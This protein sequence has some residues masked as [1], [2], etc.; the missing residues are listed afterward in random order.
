MKR[1]MQE[2]CENPHCVFALAA[3]IP[4]TC[5]LS[6]KG[7]V[8]VSCAGCKERNVRNAA[9]AL[10]VPGAR[11]RERGRENTE[12]M[13]MTKFVIGD[14][15]GNFK[16]LKEVLTLSGLDYDKDKLII[17]GDVCDGHNQTKECVDE[18]LKIK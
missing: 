14:I 6:A 13:Q 9:I 8:G 16:A 10:G 1:P 12:V 7:N 11:R 17:L 2:W 3:G 4:H 5:A 18:L 15:H